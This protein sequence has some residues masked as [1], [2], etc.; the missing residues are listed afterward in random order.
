MPII[1]A[2]LDILKPKGRKRRDTGTG[3]KYCLPSFLATHV[4]G[5]ITEER[6]F[7]AAE[8]AG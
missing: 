3:G 7:E 4:A 1:F 8:A 2:Q 6:S 5:S